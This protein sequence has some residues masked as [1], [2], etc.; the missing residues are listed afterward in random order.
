MQADRYLASARSRGGLPLLYGYCFSKFVQH[1]GADR[2]VRTTSFPYGKSQKLI[3]RQSETLGGTAIKLGT[4]DFIDKD[5]HLVKTG[6]DS[7]TSGRRVAEID[8]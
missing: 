4:I 5:T 6:N 1:G 2:F 3:H 7:V 8:T